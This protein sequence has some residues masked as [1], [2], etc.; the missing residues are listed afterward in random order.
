MSFLYVGVFSSALITGPCCPG[1]VFRIPVPRSGGSGSAI[2]PIPRST[3]S[4]S[5]IDPVPRS[6]GRGSLI[7]SGLED[8]SFAYRDALVLR[9]TAAGE[10]QDAQ[11]RGGKGYVNYLRRNVRELGDQEL[12]PD[13]NV[14]CGLVRATWAGPAAGGRVGVGVPPPLGLGVWTGWPWQLTGGAPGPRLLHS[15]V[16]SE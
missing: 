4:G 11:G 14:V 3:G 13:I 10:R 12:D 15:P 1:G 16:G 9:V 7:T 5:M 6:G 2:T 8:R